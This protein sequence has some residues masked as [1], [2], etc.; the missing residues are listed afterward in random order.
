MF[1]WKLLFR[2]FS[3]MVLLG[4][5]GFAAGHEV[6][7]PFVSPPEASA[8]AAAPADSSTTTTT[9]PAAVDSTSTTTTTAPDSSAPVVVEPVSDPTTTTTAPAKPAKPVT[10]TTAPAAPVDTPPAV[11]VPGDAP[12]VCAAAATAT[13]GPADPAPPVDDSHAARVKRCQDWWNSLADAFD[14]NGEPQWATRAREIA[15]QCDAM[16]T[17]W[18]QL[19][20]EWAQHHQK[21]DHNGDGHPDNGWH[22]KQDG[23][24]NNP[25]PPPAQPQPKVKQDSRHGEGRH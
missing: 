12:S 17:R 5:G 13:C 16:I 19:Q 9:A 10:T 24:G 23:Q 20:Q 3:A 22:N 14:H 1:P 11:P 2:F 7:L 6:S 18:E 21:G 8:P 4:T 15:G 25:A